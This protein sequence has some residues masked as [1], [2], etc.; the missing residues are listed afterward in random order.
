MSGRVSTEFENIHI[1][2]FN[3]SNIRK[4]DPFLALIVLLLA[5]AGFM[6]LY[7]T[8]RSASVE[9]PYY[10]RQMMF[11]PIGCV[12]AA[13]FLCT[14]YRFLISLGPFF[15]VALVGALIAV[16][17]WGVEAK[18]ATRWL[19]FGLFRL[20]PSEQSKLALIFML[21]WYFRTVGRKIEKLPYFLLTFVITAV[22]ALL[23]FKQ[24][25]LGTAATMPPITVAMLFVAGCRRKHLVGIIIL[26]IAVAPIGWTQMTDYQRNRVVT[27]FNPE[28]D[29]LGAAYHTTQSMITVGSGGL[30]GKGYMEGTQTYL[31]YLPEHHTDFIFS[32]LAEEWGFIGSVTVIGLFVLLFLRGLQFAHTSEDIT[33]ALLAVGIVSL[34]AFHVFVN[35]AITLG[36]AP[37]TGIPLPFLSYGRSFYLTTMMCMGVL[38]SVNSRKGMFQD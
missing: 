16:S 3:L 36:I 25:N 33:G 21:T 2:V 7:S 1:R 11:F 31:S 28:S 27:I 32:L 35:I 10:L 20:Q 14:D 5:I 34:L 4:I 29:V 22:P 26:G 38:L 15:Y 37:V 17:L 13:A 30:S 23:I 18:G 24:P 8:I 12:I 19:D 6:V 9:T